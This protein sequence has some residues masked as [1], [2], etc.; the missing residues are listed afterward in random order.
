METFEFLGYKGSALVSVKDKVLYGKILDIKDTVTYQAETVNDLRTAFVDA[1]SDYIEEL[2]KEN[3]IEEALIAYWGERC[4]DYD[5]NC[6][7]CQAWAEYDS[8]QKGSN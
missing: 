2:K 6:Y 3:K 1:V 7:C 8:L 4:E 5:E